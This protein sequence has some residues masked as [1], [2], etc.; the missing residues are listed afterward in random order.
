[1]TLL[2]LMIFLKIAKAGG[3]IGI[4]NVEIA[5]ALEIGPVRISRNLRIL[6]ELGLIRQQIH[7]LNY[8]SN[9]N[10]LSAQGKRLFMEIGFV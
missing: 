6:T 7:P 10:A 4:S 2:Q 3:D 5:T 9:L 8:R 1:M